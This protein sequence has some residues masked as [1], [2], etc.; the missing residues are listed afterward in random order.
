M[1][2]LSAETSPYLL[3]H[4][5]NPVE[6]YP[7][8]SEALAKARRENKPILLSIGY[9]ACH[10]C[11]VMAHESFEDPEVA[12][13]MNA[14]YI[15]IKVDREERPDLDRIYQLAHQAMTHRGGG[16]PLT[17]FLTPDEQLPIFAG[18]Y[19]PK[20]T[21]HGMPG[22]V[23]VLK[24]VEQFYRRQ[25]EELG[26]QS[27]QLKA[28]FDAY[29]AN[30][31]HAEEVKTDWLSR[32]QKNLE[33]SFD[34]R[35]GG[36]GS[37]PKFPHPTH[38]E[39]LLRNWAMNP[40]SEDGKRAL[41][42]ARLTLHAMASGGIYDQLGGGFCRYSTDERWA[43]PHFEKMLYDNGPLLALYAEAAIA[44]GEKGFERVAIE[45][46]NWVMREM[47]S[48]DG[49]YFSS[50]DADS[51]G[52]EGKYYVWTPEQIDSVLD[53]ESA[54][55]ARRHWGL[56]RP[57]NFE[58]HWHLVVSE[59]IESLAVALNRSPEEITTRISQARDQL[60]REREQRIRPGR[61]EKILTSWNSLMIRGMAIAGRRLQQPGFIESAS[62]AVD[63]IRNNMWVEGRLLATSK[64]GRTHLDAYLDDYVFLIDSILALLEARWRTED[65]QFAVE[66]VEV[67]LT[68]FVAVDGGFFFTADDHEQLIQRPRTWMDEA[69]PSGNGIAALVLLR[70]G[71]LLAEPRYIDAAEA[72][73]E[74][75]AVPI[76]EYAQ[77]HCSLLNAA[78]ELI[79]PTETILLRGPTSRLPGW[80]SP[81]N[82]QYVP[83]RMVFAIPDQV[84]TGFTAIDGHAASNEG[85][86]AYVCRD[87]VCDP[88][89]N[90]ID[91][92]LNH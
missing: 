18:T 17:V 38:I 66:L 68:H 67:M 33:A 89:I 26:N 81:L 27:R 58:G 16:W 91:D 78:E 85:V 11:H 84:S 9:S 70:L 92:L 63:F 6:W 87:G 49:G 71:Y 5:D 29:D 14:L 56:N 37:A 42:M 43:I 76:Q 47:Q 31:G 57:A 23:D 15:N 83:A 7:W 53:R 20:Q 59:S 2:L 35:Y 36:F 21:R 54:D 51:E 28:F 90:D 88:P 52:E 48:A 3:Q 24:R 39:R 82:Q 75:A 55:I 64:D 69:I 65:L 44:T 72:T 32:A 61:D 73:L 34:S 10:W 50:L 77:A 1:N 80:I 30:T 40:R 86:L 60:F 41:D 22:F 79:T 19:F 25:P 74:A 46:G 8:G 12:R 4:A 13:L 45:T 62:R